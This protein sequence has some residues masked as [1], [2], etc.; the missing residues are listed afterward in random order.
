MQTKII[1]HQP[2]I[3]PKSNLKI[4]VWMDPFTKA[5][6]DPEAQ[7][8]TVNTTHWKETFKSVQ[9]DLLIVESVWLQPW[10]A[11]LRSRKEE[12]NLLVTILKY[13]RNY[14]IPS[15]F[16]NKEDPP[17][18]LKFVFSA[19]LKYI[20]V[21]FTTEQRV[22]PYYKHFLKHDNVFVST[23][24]AQPAVHSPIGSRRVKKGSYAFAGTYAYTT[25][26]FNRGP[27]LDKLLEPALAY[28]LSIFDRNLAISPYPKFLIPFP[29][30][31][32][33]S[34]KGA[35]DY[36][37]V[38]EA[39]KQYNV[40]LSVNS[41]N[42]S[43]TMFSRRVLEISMSGTPV[44]SSASHALAKIL[45]PDGV[46]LIHSKQETERVM[47][48]LENPLERQ[49]TA[50]R[51]QRYILARETTEHRL[52][53]FLDKT[54]LS[55][56]FPPRSLG[57]SV[58][59]CL[60]YGKDE[61][62]DELA[63]DN[64]GDDHNKSNIETSKVPLR[65]DDDLFVE[66][67]DECEFPQLEEYVRN[68]Q[69]LSCTDKELYIGVYS[70]LLLPIVSAN[71]REELGKLSSDPNVL[72][73]SALL[74]S[75][76]KAHE[77]VSLCSPK[78]FY[79]AKGIRKIMSTRFPDITN[80]RVF[81]VKDWGR[82]SCMN[83]AIDLSSSVPLKSTT[84]PNSNA[85]PSPAPYLLFLKTGHF[86][87]KNFLRDA[88]PA[89]DYTDAQIVG[90]SSFYAVVP[91]RT[92]PVQLFTLNSTLSSSSILLTAVHDSLAVG[93][94]HHQPFAE[95]EFVESISA[96]YSSIFKRSFF[97]QRRVWFSITSS[98]PMERLLE[99][100]KRDK[101]VV[102]SANRHNFIYKESSN[103]EPV[104]ENMKIFVE[105]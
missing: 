39:Y 82:G 33:S 92:S 83:K 105:W 34:L 101:V 37:E 47:Q 3:A 90:K 78:R 14:G 19:F 55:W 40:F 104:T 76:T 5:C 11:F 21:V 65:E 48:K 59:A 38:L 46:F 9:P 89:F 27:D 85:R 43:S 53:G 64:G 80:Y 17:N 23:F 49:L 98:I 18:F 88:V 100:C 7:L 29:A 50:L 30:P 96:P 70:R 44:I 91:Q 71:Q 69:R 84:G 60:E 58:V 63:D 87:G 61:L 45:G 4:I 67:F 32:Q 102:Y 12:G 74:N 97:Y 28:D 66:N 95:H 77:L 13:A 20:D 41:V 25:R 16:W 51:A 2:V 31:Y 52:R 36:S 15:V 99:Q 94:Y 22:V 10:N 6:F 72:V 81:E 79:T 8:Y 35:L 24:S 68:F 56:K 93:L 26:Y 86:Y 1:S 42:D 75:G 62:A 57:V 103:S 54:G 73:N